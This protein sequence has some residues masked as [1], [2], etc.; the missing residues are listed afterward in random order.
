[1]ELS[2]SDPETREHFTS[3]FGAWISDSNSSHNLRLYVVH[4]Y[5]FSESMQQE[6]LACEVF[7]SIC[8][9]CVKP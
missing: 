7:V 3:S 8:D 2:L 4:V 5:V 6:F 9:V 1:M